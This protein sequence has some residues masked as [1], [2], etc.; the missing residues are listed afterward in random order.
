MHPVATAMLTD[1]FEQSAHELVE[2]GMNE[3]AARGASQKD[4][5]KSGIKALFDARGPLMTLVRAVPGWT[6]PI[7]TSAVAAVLSKT[8]FIDNILPGNNSFREAKFIMKQIA[9]AL[10]IGAGSGLRDALAKVDEAVDAVR[11]DPN[12]PDADLDKAWDWVVVSYLMRGRVFAP[13]RSGGAIRRGSDNVPIVNDPD[14]VSYKG[15]WDSTHKATTKQVSGGK[16]QKPQTVPVP[17]EAF[18]YELLKLEEAIAGGWLSQATPTDLAAIRAMLPKQ[19]QEWWEQV[20][21]DVRRMFLLI[22]RSVRQGTSLQYTLREDLVK[23]VVDKK[24]IPFLRDLATFYNPRAT[25]DDR[26]LSE[27]LEDL[28]AAF[29]TALGSELT[30]WNKIQRRVSQVWNGRGSLSA[31]TR[32]WL[33]SLFGLMIF[34]NL[35]SVALFLSAFLGLIAGSL[36][37]YDE[38]VTFLGT[39]YAE[40]KWLAAG[41]LLGGG[42]TIIVM[43][44]TLRVWQRILAPIFVGIFKAPAEYLAEFGWR[45]T[46]MLLPLFAFV[47]GALLMESSITVRVVIVAL[48]GMSISSGM[49]MKVAEMFGSARLLTYRGAKWGGIVV[50]AILALDWAIRVRMPQIVWGGISSAAKYVWPFFHN[51]WG[52][53]FGLFVLVMA[54]GM[55]AL[56]LFYRSRTETATH[57]YVVRERHGMATFILFLLAIGIAVTIPWFAKRHWEYDPFPKADT[58]VTVPATP[59]VPAVVPSRPTAPSHAHAHSGELDCNLLSPAGKA[60]YDCP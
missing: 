19:P 52:A 15:M 4:I 31:Y 17:A 60:A 57:R 38:P 43:L 39:T 35:A 42:I 28:L 55:I 50:L 32:A 54:I 1:A 27:D 40:P 3:A 7:M 21:S 59:P 10:V 49:G 58:A 44:F 11:S 25:A 23:D 33:Y 48:A 30:A 13:A 8:S 16:G 22:S 14:W 37:P 20:G 45:F 53:M 46:F 5:A 12:T 29:D 34:L 24:G 56:R 47:I 18:P 2:S 9:P 51:Q 26:F 41:L 6:Y 36:M